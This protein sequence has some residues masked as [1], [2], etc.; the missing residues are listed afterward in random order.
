MAVRAV[1]T[2]PESGALSICYCV[3]QERTDMSAAS[4]ISTRVALLA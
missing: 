4:E 3:I 2:N 1:L